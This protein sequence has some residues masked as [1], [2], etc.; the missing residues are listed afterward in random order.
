[1]VI[2]GLL[3]IPMYYIPAPGFSSNP[4]GVLEDALDGFYQMGHNSTLALAQI[5]SIFS[6]AFF[7]FFG[8]SVTKEFSATTRYLFFYSQ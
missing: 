3:L 5:G 7:N 6:I 1:M 8:L 4:R 2:L